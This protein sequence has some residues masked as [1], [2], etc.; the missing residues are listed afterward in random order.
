M[1][2][3]EIM[4]KLVCFNFHATLQEHWYISSDLPAECVTHSKRQSTAV[5][6]VQY[7]M[8]VSTQM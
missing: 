3:I 6:L 8:S 1:R 2:Y 5:F 7:L 4:R